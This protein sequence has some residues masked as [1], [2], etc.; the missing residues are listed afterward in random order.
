MRLNKLIKTQSDG[1]IEMFEDKMRIRNFNKYRD[2]TLIQFRKTLVRRL[3]K[4]NGTQ[5]V[6]FDIGD[7]Q[8]EDNEGKPQL[9]YDSFRC[10]LKWGFHVYKR[11]RIGRKTFVDKV[12]LRKQLISNFTRQIDLKCFNRNLSIPCNCKELDLDCKQKYS[13]HTE[14]TRANTSMDIKLVLSENDK[15]NIISRKLESDR[16]VQYR[17]AFNDVLSCKF[18]HAPELIEDDSDI[19]SDTKSKEIRNIIAYLFHF[20][21]GS[22]MVTRNPK[23]FQKPKFVVPI[24]DEDKDGYLLQGY[25]NGYVNKVY[26]YSILNKLFGILYREG[27]N[28]DQ[29][30]I[31]MEVIPTESLIVLRSKRDHRSYVKVFDTSL[32]STHKPLNLRGDCLL[33]DHF[34]SLETVSIIGLV[35]KKRVERLISVSSIGLGKC[36]NNCLFV[37]ELQFINYQNKVN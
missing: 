12:R 31:M 4:Q 25:D 22:Y 37:K 30:I 29:N 15:K 32:I 14:F 5:E 11:D 35:N 27:M 24:A 7:I 6:S 23:P 3:M 17:P 8:E 34:D 18:Y 13:I 21:D 1:S 9:N 19:T 10:S 26:I 36:V 20:D 16:N 2:E 28:K 33:Q